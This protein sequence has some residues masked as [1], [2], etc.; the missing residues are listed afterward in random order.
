MSC[1]NRGQRHQVKSAVFSKV[2]HTYHMLKRRFG[3]A[4]IRYKGL[5]K[6]GQTGTQREI[7]K[8]RDGCER[9]EVAGSDGRVGHTPPGDTRR[10]GKRAATR[11]PRSAADAL[12]RLAAWN[13]TADRQTRI[14]A[15]GR[16]RPA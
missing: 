10:Q 1:G 14:S 16:L 9:E 3:F 6:N 4:K 12:P 7:R 8:P 13:A 5:E 2:E 11:G 15:S